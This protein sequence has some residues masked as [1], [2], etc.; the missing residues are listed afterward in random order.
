MLPKW[1]QSNLSSSSR[2]HSLLAIISSHFISGKTA[3]STALTSRSR[4]T[5]NRVLFHLAGQS[6]IRDLCAFAMSFSVPSE[7]WRILRTTTRHFPS[8]FYMP[9]SLSPSFITNCNECARQGRGRILVTSSASLS[10]A[11]RSLVIWLISDSLCLPASSSSFSSS[12]DSSSSSS[13]C[14]HSQFPIHLVLAVLLWPSA[15]YFHYLW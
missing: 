7:D 6:L 8:R 1:L 11:S 3:F 10:M 9:V 14:S 15:Y 12:S 13:R 2:P 4:W 5:L